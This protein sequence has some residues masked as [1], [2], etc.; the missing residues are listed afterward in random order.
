MQ[1]IRCLHGAAAHLAFDE[2]DCFVVTDERNRHWLCH[3][4]TEAQL[5][6]SSSD[7]DEPKIVFRHRRAKQMGLE[8]ETSQALLKCSDPQE[9]AVRLSA[10]P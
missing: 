2:P 10:C 4:I 9:L 6:Y 8:Y 7:G 1:Y 5:D 3:P